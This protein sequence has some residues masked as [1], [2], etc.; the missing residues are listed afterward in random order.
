MEAPASVEEYKGSSDKA[1][2]DELITIQGEDYTS[3]NSSSIHGVAEYDTSVDPYQAK[4]TV[5]NTLDSDSFNTAGQTVS[6]EFE[7]KVAGNYKIAANYRQSEKTTS[8]YSVMLQS[9]EKFQ[10]CFQRLQH[11]IFNKI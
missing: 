8:R 10:Y 1:D 3:T 11:G 5:L 7:V 6:Y 9:T 4:D 2:G